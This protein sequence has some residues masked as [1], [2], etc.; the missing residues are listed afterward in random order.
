[1]RFHVDTLIGLPEG[2]QLPSAEEE[3]EE[4]PKQNSTTTSPEEPSADSTE[5]TDPCFPRKGGPGHKD[6]TP[7]QLQIIHKLFDNFGIS[8][9]RP[10]F[11][12]STASQKNQWLWNICLR[13]FHKLVECGEYK[14]VAVGG[15][16]DDFIKKCL[17]TYAKS[18]S[19]R[20]AHNLY[21]FHLHFRA[22]LVSDPQMVSILQFL[23]FV[24]NHGIPND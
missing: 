3:E 24:C 4:E 6:S 10:D 14:G 16:N 11:K 1:M 5:R 9:F 17:D 23:D 21:T 13:I 15:P 22:Y 18:L 12:K 8:S 19:K 7:Q 20:Q 2:S